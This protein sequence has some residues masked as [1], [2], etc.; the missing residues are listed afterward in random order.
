MTDAQTLTVRN[1][2]SMV[3]DLANMRTVLFGGADEKR[4]YGDLW[5]LKKKGWT[6][7]EANGPSPRTFAS[8]I[9]DGANDR[10]ILFGGNSVLFGNEA[11]PAQFLNDTWEYTKGNWRRFRTKNA[12]EPRSSAA[13]AYD[14]FNKRTVL[15]GGYS[16][17]NGK[18]KRFGDTW[19]FK[20]GKWKKLS[21]SG[22][23]PRVGAEM[24]FD[25]HENRIILFG[26]ST[27]GGDYGP[28]S[29]ETWVLTDNKWAKLDISQPPNIFNSNIVFQTQEKRLFRFGGWNGKGR[30]NETWIFKGSS[31]ELLDLEAK[32]AA[33][34]HASMVYDF[35]QNQTILFGG[36]DGE[37]IFG[38]LWI[39]RHGKW[40]KEL[41]HPPIKRKAN[42]H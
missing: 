28:D 30:I 8:L 20:N 24:S 19:E 38:D 7:L 33:R 17:E 15:F 11:N 36:H 32:P 23:S 34:N 13:M 22:P 21:Q 37:K 9:S 12:P 14:S 2:H 41:E 27:D 31:W 40:Y 3:Y 35:N 6:K 1:A 18:N 10:L 26:G 42:G 4:V 25:S 5:V 29:G 39:F 16:L